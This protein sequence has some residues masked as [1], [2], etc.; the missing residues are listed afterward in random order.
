MT[1]ERLQA[2][3]ED[4][5]EVETRDEMFVYEELLKAEP[6]G[7]D[8]MICQA[9]EAKRKILDDPTVVLMQYMVE[10][11]ELQKEEAP[12]PKLSQTPVAK[13]GRKYRLLNDDV[14][15]S[16]TPQVHA[17][18]VI[19]KSIMKVGDIVDEAEIIEAMEKNKEV[20]NTRQPSVRIWKY[21]S[22]NSDKGLQTHGNIEKL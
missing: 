12:Q 7:D 2:T 4:I 5:S 20:L 6:N 17:I 9:I 14:N 8:P 15:W 22:G 21:Y 13:T 3:L 16:T 19:L 11:A 18:M 10:L 1:A